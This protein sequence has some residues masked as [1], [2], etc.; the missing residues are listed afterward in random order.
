[1]ELVS[2]TYAGGYGAVLGRGVRGKIGDTDS[3][4]PVADLTNQ[5]F[6]EDKVT[7]SREGK[8]RASRNGS[9]SQAAFSTSNNNDAELDQQELEQLQQLK[10]RDTEVRAHEQAH[11]LAAGRYATSGVSFTYQRGPDGASY[12]IGGEVGISLGE[13]STPEATIVKMQTVQRAALAPADPSGT[14]KRIAAEATAKE[15]KAR[16]ELLQVKQEALLADEESRPI[17]DA[18]RHAK[19]NS[20]QQSTGNYQGSINAKLAVYQNMAG[21]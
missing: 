12:A 21:S 13:E 9:T 18:G 2:I 3:S 16:Q 7:L 17:Q 14:D 8:D 19:K 15:A 6:G 10:D 4:W 11:L 20:V 1:M 5:S